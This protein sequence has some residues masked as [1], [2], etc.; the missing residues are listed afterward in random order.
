[1]RRL[2]GNFRRILMDS[3]GAALTEYVLLLST[4]SLVVIIAFLSIVNSVENIV[5][6]INCSILEVRYKNYISKS[7]TG[8]S[9]YLPSLLKSIMVMGANF[10]LLMERLNA[11]FTRGEANLRMGM[12]EIMVVFRSFNLKQI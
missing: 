6:S 3:R 1:M 7:Q 9:V 8:H 10:T 5:C 12:M 11:V 4:I 2:K